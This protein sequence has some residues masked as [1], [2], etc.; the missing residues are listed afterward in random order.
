[1]FRDLQELTLH[2]P[3]C[4]GVD[5]KGEVDTC[6]IWSTKEVVDHGGYIR[7]DHP[8][9]ILS[10]RVE[11]MLFSIDNV[12]MGCSWFP[13]RPD[14]SDHEWADNSMVEVN[15]TASRRGLNLGP[16]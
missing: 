12:V 1:M 8:V 6:S 4:Q 9:D 5:E 7:L 15:A 2:Y 16:V 14:G 11:V 10:A 3:T 13:P